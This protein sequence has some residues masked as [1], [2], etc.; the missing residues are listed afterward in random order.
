[1]RLLSR[2]TGRRAIGVAVILAGLPGLS[3]CYI[4]EGVNIADA[5]EEMA[6]F[7]GFLQDCGSDSDT[8]RGGNQ[9]ASGS[10]SSSTSSS[11]SNNTGGESTSQPDGE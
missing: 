2:H 8:N 1:M 11:N 5:Y 3:G 9:T 10:S 7:C 4:P 6:G